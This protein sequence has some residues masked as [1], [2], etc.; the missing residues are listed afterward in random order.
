MTLKEAV[1]LA[2]EVGRDP[3]TR[4]WLRDAI[5]RTFSMD[6]VDALND[7]ELLVRLLKYRLH[8]IETE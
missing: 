6:P 3:G 5:G 2:A 1:D 8:A 4:Y 7:A